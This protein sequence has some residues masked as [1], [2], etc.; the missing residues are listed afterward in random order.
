MAHFSITSMCGYTW[1]H[2]P[3]ILVNASIAQLMASD[4]D[5]SNVE[6]LAE[7]GGYDGFAHATSQSAIYYW[8]YTQNNADLHITDGTINAERQ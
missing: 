2:Q 6:L 4:M 1:W 5:G 3:I 8:D 7:I